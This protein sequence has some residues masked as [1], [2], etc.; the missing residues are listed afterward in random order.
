MWNDYLNLS[1]AHG[2][3]PINGVVEVNIPTTVL[4]D[5]K[6]G[7]YPNTINLGSNGVVPVAIL[8][9]D[10]FDAITVDATTVTLTSASV[11]LRGNGLPITEARDV[12]GDGRVDLVVQVNTKLYNSQT[13]TRRLP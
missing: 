5:V 11:R 7:S 2:V 12:N 3:I 8:S 6:P 13:V 9:T 10:T 1:Y 4:I